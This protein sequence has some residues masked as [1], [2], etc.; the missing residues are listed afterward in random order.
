MRRFALCLLL[1]ATLS[2]Q[3]ADRSESSP[4]LISVAGAGTVA[5]SPDM[6]IVT[7]GVTTQENDAASAVAANN[8][9]MAALN[10]ALD[11]FDIE[12]RDR[13]SRGFSVQPQYDHRR[14][15]G[16]MPEV[17]GFTVQVAMKKRKMGRCA[18]S[19]IIRPTE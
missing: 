1:A 14:N 6:A 13:R 17:I 3:A 12:E 19:M 10:K 7:V 5:A 16:G 8:H 11:K 15:T 9:A 4:A 2:C 18:R